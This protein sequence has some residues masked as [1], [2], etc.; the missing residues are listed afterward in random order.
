[1]FDI[2]FLA[3]HRKRNDW[4]G[5]ASCSLK[6]AQYN[7]KTTLIHIYIVH[8]CKS[9]IHH[10]WD[11]T[12]K[13]YALVT[14]NVKYAWTSLSTSLSMPLTILL[15]FSASAMVLTFVTV[16]TDPLNAVFM[17]SESKAI[18]I[19]NRS[20]SMQYFSRIWCN[21]GTKVFWP[22]ADWSGETQFSA[23]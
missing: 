5:K 22:L 2:N 23:Q 14:A 20:I 1:M 7:Y 9:C 10:C 8:Y 4:L 21:S 11:Q 6:N 15:W 17:V 18:C 13:Q 3:I 19:F 16:L 12:S